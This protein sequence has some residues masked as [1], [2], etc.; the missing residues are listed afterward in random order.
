MYREAPATAAEA[1]GWTV[2]WYDRERVFHHA[3]VA[4]GREEVDTFPR[5]MGQ[6]IGPPWQ[7]RHK[8]AAATAMAT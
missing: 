5:A 8:F 3:A 7:A 1:Q 4:L 2:H 6:T